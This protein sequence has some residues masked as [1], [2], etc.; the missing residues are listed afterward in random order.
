M[1]R[2]FFGHIKIIKDVDA[3]HFDYLFI[4]ITVTKTTDPIIRTLTTPQTAPIIAS[5]FVAVA[6]V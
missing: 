1:Y 6:S 2:S 4:K 5:E 3:Y